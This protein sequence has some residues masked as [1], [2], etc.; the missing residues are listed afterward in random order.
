MKTLIALLGKGQRGGYRKAN[1][2]FEPNGSSYTYNNFARAVLEHHLQTGQPF[3]RL[4]LLGTPGSNWDAFFMEVELPL[5][6]LDQEQTLEALAES[7]FQESVS[8][9]Q[10]Y[11]LFPLL[12]EALGCEVCPYIIPHARNEVEQVQILEIMAR[13]ATGSSAVWLDVTH[14]FRHL[15]MLALVAAR[16]LE[17]VQG[18]TVEDILYGAFEMLEDNQTPVIHLGG[19]SVLL[20]GVEALASFDKDGD[21]GV[22]SPFLRRAQ[23]PEGHIEALR[24]ASY[25]ERINN[26]GKARESLVTV[27]Q[28]LERVEGPIMRFLAPAIQER[29]AWTRLQGRAEWERALGDLYFQRRDYLRAITF[30]QEGCVTREAISQNLSPN[31]H[32]AREDARN[33]LRDEAAFRAL[34]WLRNAMVHGVRAPD[35]KEPKWKQQLRQDLAYEDRLCTTLQRLRR[36]L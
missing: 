29:T 10:L 8:E 2:R 32:T 5:L 16:F 7:V 30:W 6:S 18:I 35:D 24:C 26:P 25:F 21:Y 34:S 22:F 19:I 31:A 27:T 36:E 11:D 20:S 9:E 28:G 3:E 23:A 1:Y 33:R 12:N 4:V 17:R 14:G 15:P 13:A